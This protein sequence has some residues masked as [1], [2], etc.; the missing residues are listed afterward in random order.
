[1]RSLAAGVVGVFFLWAIWTAAQTGYGRS[2]AENGSETRQLS[3]LDKAVKFSPFDPETHYNRAALLW[4]AD[5]KAGAIDEAERAVALRPR[6]YFLWFRL[7]FYRYSSEDKA[8]ALAPFKE[9]T[10]LA[11]YY[12]QPHFF[13]GN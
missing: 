7:G 10:R 9:A 5:D 4:A 8:G 12:A 3:L 6:D 2:L 1:M 11:P 13:I